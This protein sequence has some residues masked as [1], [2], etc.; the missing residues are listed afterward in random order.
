MPPSFNGISCFVEN[1]DYH[2][3]MTAHNAIASEF[4]NHNI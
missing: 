4:I 2:D 1:A 3:W